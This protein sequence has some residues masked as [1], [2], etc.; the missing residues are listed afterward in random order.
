VPSHGNTNP[1][2]FNADPA[3]LVNGI[4]NI[5]NDLFV[6]ILPVPMLWRVQLPKKQRIGLITLFGVGSLVNIAGGLRLYYSIIVND[7][8]DGTWSGFQLWTW[9]AVEVDLGIACA[10]AP[11][12]KPLLLRWFPNL[13]HSVFGANSSSNPSRKGLSAGGNGTFLEM[14][15]PRGGRSMGGT[16]TGIEEGVTRTHVYAGKLG[17]HKDGESEESLTDHSILGAIEHR[18]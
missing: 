9:E 4:T 18:R 12:L 2:C 7:S 5:L 8:R 1:K 3:L 17:R 15:S 6:Y 13:M 10:C 14:K 11:A 16:F